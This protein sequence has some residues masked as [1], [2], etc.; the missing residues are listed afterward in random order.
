V[1]GNKNS[2]SERKKWKFLTEENSFDGF[3]AMSDETL[4]GLHSSLIK[5]NLNNTNKKVVA[6]SEG[7]LPKY[8]DET[9][10]YQINDGYEMG[11]FAGKQLLDSI[12]TIKN[13]EL[14]RPHKVYYL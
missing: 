12:K 8:L 10:E 14:K 9:Y 7:T 3:F 6:I 11:T 5:R 13:N 2:E 4:I 1:E